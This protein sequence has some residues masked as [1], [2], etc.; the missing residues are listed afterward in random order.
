MSHTKKGA[1]IPRFK[2]G[3]KVRV[4]SGVSEPDYPDIPLGGWTGTVT[5]IIEERRKIECVFELDDRTLASLH[6]IYRKRCE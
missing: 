5:E 3:D 2:I 6:P 4:K 1:D